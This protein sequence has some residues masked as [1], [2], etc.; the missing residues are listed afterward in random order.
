M[1]KKEGGPS[2]RL[3]E[4]KESARESA[5]Q[6]VNDGSSG[7]INMIVREEATQPPRVNRKRRRDGK[8]KELEVMQVAEHI[9]SMVCFSAANGEGVDMPY[10]GALVVE[11]IIHNFKVQKILMDDS[12]KVN[13]ISYR[14]LQAIKIPKENLVRDKAPIKGIGGMPV[15]VERKIKLLLTLRTPPTAHTQYAQFL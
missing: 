10:D 3:E 9:P 2:N 14:V 7:T 5:T 12:S 1:S 8:Q 6:L 15:R 11:V 4:R 13:L